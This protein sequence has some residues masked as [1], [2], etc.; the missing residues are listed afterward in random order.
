MIRRENGIL[1]NGRLLGILVLTGATAIAGS[2]AGQAMVGTQTDGGAA[3]PGLLG[4]SYWCTNTRYVPDYAH[5]DVFVAETQ[6]SIGFN[7]AGRSFAAGGTGP[8]ARIRPAGGERVEPIS[9]PTFSTGAFSTSSQFRNGTRG[10]CVALA[11]QI[12]T[13][14]RS[15]GCDASLVH[16]SE[17]L[18]N[19]VSLSFVCQGEQEDLLQ[20][21]SELSRAVVTA[22]LPN[23]GS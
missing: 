22:R 8:G 7:G 13:R 18:Y 12:S 17:I 2:L 5:P 4:G 16:A 9:L 23:S 6:H 10:D 15:F 20:V 11:E 21:M 3:S 19:P 1:S 14:A